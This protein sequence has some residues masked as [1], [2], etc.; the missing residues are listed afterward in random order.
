MICDSAELE[1][2]SDKVATEYD[3]QPIPHCIRN[4]KVRFETANCCIHDFA[5]ALRQL[6]HD[7][8]KAATHI[9]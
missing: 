7:P 1:K 4:D 2:V 5:A 6:Q 9:P 8:I 3:D